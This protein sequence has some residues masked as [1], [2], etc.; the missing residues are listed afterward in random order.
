MSSRSRLQ[1][2]LSDSTIEYICGAL[3]LALIPIMYYMYRHFQS[4]QKRYP[5]GIPPLRED[6]KTYAE[7]VKEGKKG[8]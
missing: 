3:F 1:H 4:M 6:G 2:N 8:Q 7:A 5:G